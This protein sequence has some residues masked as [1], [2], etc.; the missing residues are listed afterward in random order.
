MSEREIK[1]EESSKI[2]DVEELESAE[3]I[4][5]VEELSDN[6]IKFLEE[7]LAQSTYKILQEE[8]IRLLKEDLKIFI[9]PYPDLVNKPFFYIK[10]H[11]NFLEGWLKKWAEVLIIFCGRNNRFVVSIDELL[12]HFPFNSTKFN[13]SLSRE[14]LKLIIDKLV[15]EGKAKWLD[16]KK[17]VALIYWVSPSFIINRILLHSREIGFKYITIHLLDRV[18]S[19]L[20]LIEKIA[21]LNTIVTENKGIWIRKNY[22]IRLNL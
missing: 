19:D 3:K 15:E 10:P 8:L 20:P 17:E 13:K 1:R 21:L 2:E 9:R 18:F 11:K 12:S 6:S 5:K 16:E 7:L 4:S 22:A 14:D